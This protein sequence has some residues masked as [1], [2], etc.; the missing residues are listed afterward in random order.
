MRVH[1][2]IVSFN[3]IKQTLFHLPLNL[4]LPNLHTWLV[5]RIIL[6]KQ[7]HVLHPSAEL[8]ICPFWYIWPLYVQVD[9]SAKTRKQTREKNCS[10]FSP[11]TKASRSNMIF[12]IINVTSIRNVEFQL[13]F[14]Y[15]NLCCFHQF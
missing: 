2:K 11:L 7:P 14:V 15:P 13:F 6:S 9:W 1:V 8:N 10:L 12:F 3:D 5:Q 4:F